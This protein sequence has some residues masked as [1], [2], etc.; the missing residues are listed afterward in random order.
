MQS[1]KSFLVLFLFLSYF[2]FSQYKIGQWVDHLSY[3]NA[4]SV[5]KVGNLVYVSNGFGLATYN[6][7]DNSVEKL[8][9][10]NGLS[11]IGVKLLRKNEYNNYLLVVYDNTNIDVIKP[12]GKIINVSDIK[13]KIIQ[14][15]KNINEVHFKGHLAYIACGFGIIV[16]DTQKMEVKDTYYLGTAQSNLEVNQVT[17]TDTAIFAATPSGIFYGKISENLSYYQ[18]WKSL[19]QGIPSGAYNS[20]VN[21]KGLILANYSKPNKLLADTIYQFNGASW[22]K[23]PYKSN[24]TNKKLYDY[25]SYNKLLVN[26]QWGVSV[27]NTDGTSPNFTSNY[28]FDNAMIN[29]VCYEADLKLW[30]ADARYGLIK[31]SGY[32]PYYPN[33]PIT[34]EGAYN[35][36]SK[37]LDAMD[38]ILALAPIDLGE[39][40]DAQYNNSK[41]SIFSDYSWKYVS[42]TPNIPDINSVSIDP[43]DKNHIAFGCMNSG[44]M[45]VKDGNVKAV[46]NTTNSPLQ[47]IGGGSDLRVT[48]VSYDKNSNLW[49]SITFGSRAI[50]VLK[51]NNTWAHLDFSSIISSPTISK[52]IFDKTNQAW[53]VLPRNTGLMVYKDVLGLS[54]PNSSNTKLLNTA[55]GNGRL[56]SVDIYSVCEDKNGHIWVGTA[57]GITVFYTPE[58]IFKGGNWDS[59]QILIE[60]DGQVQILLENDVITSITVDGTNRKWIGTQASGVY[61]LSEDGQKDIYHF[62]AENSPLYSNRINDIAINESTGDV[63]IATDKGVQSYRISNI[64]GYEEFTNVQAYPNPVRPGYSGPVCITGLVDQTDLKITDLYGNLVWS[65]TSQGGQVEWNQLNF[66][67]NKVAS[68]IYLVFCSSADGEKSA[69]TKLMIIN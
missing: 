57:K 60:Q 35:N 48:G 49:A 16:F 7:E 28:G 61:C 38:D 23:Y 20:I 69:S 68:G 13:R 26:D 32:G 11:D 8:T 22:R 66:S 4:N 46:Y 30:F 62:T 41:A 52:I 19:H 58:N 56:P 21:F 44:I 55:V 27:I 40:Y 5:A 50:S 29:D 6:T 67:G 37:D 45:E 17:T 18:N 42:P 15:K 3:N 24:S 53:I 64:K 54:K 36:F 31:S 51:N 14:G 43:R 65:A 39:T 47:G 10:I 1:K 9:K 25:S 59:Q 33:E 12:D 2:S 34:L 63:F